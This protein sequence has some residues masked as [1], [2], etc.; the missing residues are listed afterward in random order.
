MGAGASFAG[1]GG[2]AILGS[3]LLGSRDNEV[4]GVARD[5]GLGMAILGGALFLAGATLV[6]IDLLTAPAPTPDG[7]GAQLV[8]AF[9]F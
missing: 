4:R 8:L 1:A 3:R 7:R 6:G 5:V 2:L 9:D